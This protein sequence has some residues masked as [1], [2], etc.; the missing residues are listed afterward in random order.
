MTHDPDAVLPLTGGRT[1]DGPLALLHAYEFA[2]SLLPAKMREHGTVAL[3][4]IFPGTFAAGA[5]LL[6]PMWFD[7]AADPSM[8]WDDFD[9]PPD[10]SGPGVRWMDELDERRP[11]LR[12]IPWSEV[13]GDELVDGFTDYARFGRSTD[14]GWWGWPTTIIGPAEG[15]LETDALRG[16]VE[17]LAAAE[18]PDGVVASWWDFYIDLDRREGQWLGDH[19]TLAQVFATSL[20]YRHSPAHLV[21]L[22]ERFAL[23]TDVDLCTTFLAVDDPSLLDALEE[24]DVVDVVRLEVDQPVLPQSAA[25]ARPS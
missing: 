23:W 12:R 16:L 2:T 15:T 22:H 20:H 5:R 10:A 7:T 14:R 11:Q 9:D 4:D 19:G 8:V 21:D 1:P 17:V 18:S 6:H 3:A 25:P 13:I 24:A